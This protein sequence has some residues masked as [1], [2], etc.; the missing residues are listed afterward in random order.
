MTNVFGTPVYVYSADDPANRDSK[1]Q[2][3]SAS[4]KL[5]DV[6]KNLQPLEKALAALENADK[7]LD[8]TGYDDLRKAIQGVVQQAT[9]KIGEM[10][11]QIGGAAQQAA[12]PDSQPG[13][14]PGSQPQQPVPTAGQISGA[15]PLPGENA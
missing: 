10:V 13:S 14:Q 4:A 1:G 3:D 8:G 11:S 6:L 2:K 15:E 12:Q 7:S 9:A 5:K